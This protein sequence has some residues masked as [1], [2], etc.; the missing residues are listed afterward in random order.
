MQNIGERYRSSPST[1]EEELFD[2]LKNMMVTESGSIPENLW[3]SIMLNEEARN[4]WID[5]FTH[6]SVN[7]ERNYEVRELFGDSLLNS[8]LFYLFLGNPQDERLGAVLRSPNP[9]DLMT[10]IKKKLVS[11]P[12]LR[13]MFYTKM[14]NL[15]LYI[16][17]RPEFARKSD[18]MEDVFES[19]I[20]AIQMS[21]DKVSW[22]GKFM[23][24]GFVSVTK[25]VHWFYTRRLT[26]DEF[27]ISG[28]KDIKTL[29]KEFLEKFY[30]YTTG[31][32]DVVKDPSSDLRTYSVHL[33]PQVLGKS[34]NPFGFIKSRSYYLDPQ[35]QTMQIAVDNSTQIVTIL[36]NT[37]RVTTIKD[38]E[39]TIYN[40]LYDWFKFNKDT[41]GNMKIFENY[42]DSGI[43]TYDI[44]NNLIP[45]IDDYEKLK[46]IAASMDLDPNTIDIKR[47]E[48]KTGDI[49][50]IV[51]GKKRTTREKAIIY[52]TFIPTVKGVN[53]NTLIIDNIH[54]WLSTMTV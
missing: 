8:A 49:S 30:R 24:P 4:V 42:N 17:C 53:S 54:N 7:F 52:D 34:V 9:T 38:E 27:D 50:I 40:K 11:K 23:G 44:L 14:D 5:C 3:E 28:K 45:D 32:T 36:V 33:V 25:F 1:W 46:N 16:R 37:D 13:Q 2:K 43:T 18:L 31:K 51:W 35:N 20:S 47:S 48:F 29:M 22:D 26:A 15:H 19:F 21:V 41:S 10:Q 6:F 12:F 39:Q